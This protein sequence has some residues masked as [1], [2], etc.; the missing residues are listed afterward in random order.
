MPPPRHQTEHFAYHPRTD[1]QSEQTNQWLETY[2]RLF[3]NY[4]QDNCVAVKPP[5]YELEKYRRLQ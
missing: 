4:Q 3:V 2:L 5:H 1:G